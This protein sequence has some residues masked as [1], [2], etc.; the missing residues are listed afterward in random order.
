VEEGN[1][2][3]V[4]LPSHGGIP[5]VTGTTDRVEAFTLGCEPPAFQVETTALDLR[6]EKFDHVVV[7]Q[8]SF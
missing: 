4:E 6:L 7:A 3:V 5:L 1:I 8:A 2:I